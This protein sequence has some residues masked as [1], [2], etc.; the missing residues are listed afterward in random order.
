MK[1]VFVN[2]EDAYQKLSNS[3]IKYKGNPF[4]VTGVDTKNVVTLVEVLE[5]GYGKTSKV[6]LVD[7]WKDF[8][9]SVQTLYPFN[10]DMGD[11]TYCV[12]PEKSI[13]KS[14]HYGVNTR[15]IFFKAFTGFDTYTLDQKGDYYFRS[16]KPEYPSYHKAV[17]ILGSHSKDST[18]ALS[19]GTFLYTSKIGCITLKSL[20]SNTPILWVNRG[21]VVMCDNP[22]TQRLSMSKSSP[23][24][25]IVQEIQNAVQFQNF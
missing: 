17:K 22:L 4:I 3:I 19:K 8:D 24:S 2:S 12:I 6:S 21:E 20:Y 18:V 9:L 25:R 10:Y 14:Y 16:L 13:T 23:T 15:C 7:E 11:S 1:E 5:T